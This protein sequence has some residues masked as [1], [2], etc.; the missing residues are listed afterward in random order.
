MRA[1]NGVGTVEPWE[2]VQAMLREIL[3]FRLGNLQ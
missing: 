2:R 3:A 1:V